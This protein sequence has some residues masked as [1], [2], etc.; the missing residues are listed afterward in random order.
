MSKVV[1]GHPGEERLMR[2]ADGELTPRQSAV[3]RDHLEACWQ[4]RAEM[5]AIQGA[6]A[7]CVHY[8]KSV[9]HA[10]LPPAPARWRDLS[11]GFAAV[12]REIAAESSWWRHLWQAVSP[13]RFWVPAV[14]A[15]LVVT[16]V[17]VPWLRV[18]PT[19]Q[20]AELLRQAVLAAQS[21]PPVTAGGRKL[22]VRTKSQKLT[23]ATASSPAA[24]DLRPVK[25]LFESAQYDWND[26]LSAKA[27]LEWHDRLA[28]KTDEVT[29]DGGGFY[30]IKTRASDGALSE[31]TL[32]L[33]QDDLQPVQGLFKF[34]GDEWVEL[35][36]VPAEPDVLVAAARV[37]NP[38]NTPIDPSAAPVR[39]DLVSPAS[40]TGELRVL[41]AL[42]RVGADLGDP[43][44]VTRVG[45]Q[46]EV[47][48]F[49]IEGR[50]REQIERALQGL[51]AVNLWFVDEAAP[52]GFATEA[53]PGSTAVKSAASPLHDYLEQYLGGR[54]AIEQFANDVFD[55][56][57]LVMARAHA[58][59][60]LCAR[61]PDP[62]SLHA[63]DLSVYR[64]IQRNHARSLIQ[65]ER[66]L[67]GI[68]RTVAPPSVSP[69]SVV[70]PSTGQSL[71]QSA[72]RL[73]RSVSMLLGAAPFSGDPS[74]LP[75][76][77]AA[78]QAALEQITR[79]FLESMGQ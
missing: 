9:L 47:K 18:T 3:V 24:A 62:S 64:A 53:S 42:H 38:V 8:R 70:G 48:G 52:A 29:P 65:L 77:I 34:R 15:G 43:I 19:V 60:R 76:R 44:E 27:Y 54:M 2:L 7:D 50:R 21:R 25:A 37:N 14:A 55:R 11:A 17:L 22:Q 68:L 23:Y 66:D 13:P 59:Q 6:V 71:L 4:C 67:A 41:E 61:F 16:L 35:T 20:A 72:R 74:T 75:A 51:S 30:Q 12:D 79:A 58:I 46:V 31:A 10:H 69:L 1:P 73:E 36:E 57:E 5:E 40:V 28:S 32:R 26:A 56:Y 39:T 49:G 33:R 78:E 45:P 63:A